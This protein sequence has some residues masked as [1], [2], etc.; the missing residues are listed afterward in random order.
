[1]IFVIYQT[2][3]TQ[4]TDRT[5]PRIW[6]AETILKKLKLMLILRFSNHL[7]NPQVTF[8]VYHGVCGQQTEIFGRFQTLMSNCDALKYFRVKTTESDSGQ[9]QKF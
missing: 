2:S 8:T 9:S 4:I 6:A 3:D 7:M 1:M 5:S